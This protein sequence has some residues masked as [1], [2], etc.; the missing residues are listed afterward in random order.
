MGGSII[1]VRFWQK[2]NFMFLLPVDVFIVSDNHI[3]MILRSLTN[4]IA[5]WI[6]FFQEMHAEM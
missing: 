2:T 4:S 1:S 6:S 3:I 5:V